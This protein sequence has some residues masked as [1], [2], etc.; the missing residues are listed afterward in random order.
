[1]SVPLHASKNLT[2]KP[3]DPSSPINIA[4]ICTVW[5][6]CACPYIHGA[7]RCMSS[8]SYG[9]ECIICILY[10]SIWVLI[11]MQW[12]LTGQKSSVPAGVVGCHIANSNKT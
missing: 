3:T 5:P 8:G 11:C 7:T 10:G 4:N 12:A 6:Q 9:G 2:D 1:M